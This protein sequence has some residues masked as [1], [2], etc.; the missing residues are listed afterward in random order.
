[1]YV[2][3]IAQ[4]LLFPHF[5]AGFQDEQAFRYPIKAFGYDKDVNCCRGNLMYMEFKIIDVGNSSVVPLTPKADLEAAY[6]VVLR[7]LPPARYQND[8]LK[9][10]SDMDDVILHLTDWRTGERGNSAINLFRPVW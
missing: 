9:C 4:K 2:S 6:R 1:V 7:R 5:L 3:F 8:T 10:H